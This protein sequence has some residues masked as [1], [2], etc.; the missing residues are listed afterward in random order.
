[1]SLA[2]RLSNVSRLASKYFVVWVVLASGAA[3]ANPAPFVPVLNYVTPLL[4]L[5]MLGMGSP[6]LPSDLE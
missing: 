4:G 6:L 1:M 5:I 3:L 2:D